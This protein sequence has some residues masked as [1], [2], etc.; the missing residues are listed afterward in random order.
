LS[1]LDTLRAA[2]L[3]FQQAQ[4][5]SDVPELDRLLHPALTFV[6]PDG[7]LGDKDADLLAHESGAIRIDIL[8]PQDLMV[9]IADGV[10]I[11]VL[12][13][14]LDGDYH[15]QKFSS[16]MRYTRTWARSGEA[17]RIVAAHASAIADSSP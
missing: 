2:E 15:G 1:D 3:R 16:R 9:R 7:A 13:A 17:W 12:T 4:L 8:K 6:G 10:G 14:Q 5:A 11:T